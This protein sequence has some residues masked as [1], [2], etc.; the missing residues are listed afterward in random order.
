MSASL[1][2]SPSLSL[3][4]PLLSCGASLMAWMAWIAWEDGLV[5]ARHAAAHRVLLRRRLDVARV[6]QI[7]GT[8]LAVVPVFDIVPTAVA[9]VPVVVELVGCLL[10]VAEASSA[11][12]AA[13]CSSASTLS[14]RH[15]S[16]RLAISPRIASSSASASASPSAVSASAVI[17]VVI[18]WLHCRRQ[19]HL[20]HLCLY[21]RHL[22]LAVLQ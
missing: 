11:A 8:C 17:V 5:F 13:S 12:S 21:C 20:I 14:L 9:I 22:L 3:L 7:V 1:P 18:C 4:A 10:G 16:G 2:C 19:L 6:S 15:P